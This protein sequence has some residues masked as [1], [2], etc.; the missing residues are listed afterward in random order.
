MAGKKEPSFEEALTALEKIVDAMENGELTL[1]ELMENYGQGVTLSLK[2][3]KALDRAEKTMDIMIKDEHD[4]V[5]EL[6]LKI[7]GD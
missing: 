6:E 1:A 4:E 3:L 2:C 7:E 5:Q